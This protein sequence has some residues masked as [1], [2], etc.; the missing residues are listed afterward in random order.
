M[1]VRHNPDSAALCKIIITHAAD[2]IDRFLLH[3]RG[4]ADCCVYFSLYLKHF[5]LFSLFFDLPP[6]SEKQAA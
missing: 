3:H 6:G 2:L 1:Y 5:F 4:I